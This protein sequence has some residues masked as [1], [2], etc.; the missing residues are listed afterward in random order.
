M[1][2]LRCFFRGH[3]E[4]FHQ[5]DERVFLKCETCGRHTA[6]WDVTALTIWRPRVTRFRKRLRQLR[7]DTRGGERGAGRLQVGIPGVEAI[8]DA[9][10]KER[11]K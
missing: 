3:D 8:A 11:S 9:M 2:G 1:I 5:S 4:T 10:L 6:G 7:K